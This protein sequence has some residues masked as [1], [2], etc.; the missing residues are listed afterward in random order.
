MNVIWTWRP[1]PEKI[2]SIVK[3]RSPEL[4]DAWKRD[5]G[6]RERRDCKIMLTGCHC[7]KIRGQLVKLSLDN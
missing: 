5:I 4:S 2:A 3:A 6:K 1:N 7:S